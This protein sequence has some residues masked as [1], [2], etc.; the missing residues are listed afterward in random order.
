MYTWEPISELER[1][2]REFDNLFTGPSGAVH[3]YP[4]INVWSLEDEAIVTSEIPGIDPNSLDISVVGQ[5]VTI[6]G[7]R[8][9]EPASENMSY[10]RRER[11]HGQFSRT[12]DLPFRADAQ[13]VEA[14]YNKGVV[15][16]RLPRA[17]E[18]KPRKIA[19]KA[20]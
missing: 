8:V 11:L 4:A 19:V 12:L 9:P 15:T 2:T 20:V 14:K 10:H 5:R 6:S 16:V 1:F 17:E 13:K 7:Q 18:D 3:E